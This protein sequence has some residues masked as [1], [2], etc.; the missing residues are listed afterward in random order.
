MAW[1]CASIEAALR[2]RLAGGG[3]LWRGL[4][5]LF[6]SAS[7]PGEGEHKLMHYVRLQT[8]AGLSAGEAAIPHNPNPQ[9]QPSP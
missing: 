4:A 3:P 8:A 5:V 7:E 6:S 1:M 9:P 2:E